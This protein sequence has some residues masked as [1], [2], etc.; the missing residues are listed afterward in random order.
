MRIKCFS[1]GD[2]DGVVSNLLMCRYFNMLGYGHS[3]ETCNTGKSIDEKILAYINS[4]EYDEDTI[5]IV[6]DVCMSYDVA[7]ILNTLPN[8]KILIDHHDTSQK[9]LGRGREEGTDFEWASIQ[10]GDSATMLVFRYLYNLANTPEMKEMLDSYKPLV[11]VTD[12][13]DTKSRQSE[14]FIAWRDSIENILALQNALGIQN[15]KARFLIDP[16]IELTDT[17]TAMV[18]T[19]K[20][21][22]NNYMKYMNITVK[23]ITYKG[24]NC[25]YGIGFGGLYR[26][27]TADYI[28]E[29]NKELLFVVLIDLNETRGSL[30][31]SN[32]LIAEN[33]DLTKIAKQIDPNGGGHP[34]A[35]GFGFTLD[36]YSSIIDTFLNGNFSLD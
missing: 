28:F 1:H 17:E 32:H 25:S 19:L 35:C 5:I 22:K 18:D 26:S 6:T 31:R 27:E 36:S 4:R 34:F 11:V 3:T 15:M 23:P 20:K 14:D 29:N 12:L 2:L 8:K 24:Q 21:I 9:M 30:R 13:W 7:N 33:L 16:S 10:E